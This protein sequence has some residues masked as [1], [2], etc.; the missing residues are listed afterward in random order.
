MANAGGGGSGGEV[1]DIPSEANSGGGG[2]IILASP[3][4]NE[5]SETGGGGGGG[6][7]V[8]ISQAVM[9]LLNGI[10][11]SLSGVSGFIGD[12]DCLA[13]TA[14]ATSRSFLLC[15]LIELERGGGCG[16]KEGSLWTDK[17]VLEP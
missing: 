15:L 5:G 12:A 7:G 2:R 10:R 13:I 17:L 6:E 8:S 9:P 4:S 1:T 11:R 16:R 3:S 14:L